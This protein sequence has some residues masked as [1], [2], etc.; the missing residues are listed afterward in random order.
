MSDIADRADTLI[1]MERAV[2]LAA[3][4]KS[5]HNLVPDGHCYFCDED[6]PHDRLFCNADCR[7]DFDRHNA[8]L[9][10]TGKIPP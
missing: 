8:A 9:K 2:A 6:V 3:V 1:A 10:R 7:D 4:R 5:A